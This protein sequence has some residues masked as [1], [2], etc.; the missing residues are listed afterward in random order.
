MYPEAY[1]CQK[2][3]AH[4]YNLNLISSIIQKKAFKKQGN[5]HEDKQYHPKFSFCKL[6]LYE[7]NIYHLLYHADLL[8]TN[9]SAKYHPNAQF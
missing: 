4:Y 1:E 8:R 2:S 9:L 6:N 3:N 5:V 7:L